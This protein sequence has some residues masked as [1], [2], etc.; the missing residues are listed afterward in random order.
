MND[1]LSNGNPPVLVE[2]PDEDQTGKTIK[3]AYEPVSG[4]IIIDT[5]F[6]ADED[7]YDDDGKLEFDGN[8]NPS[9]FTATIIVDAVTNVT[10]T[11]EV[12]YSNRAFTVV[13]IPESEV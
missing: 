8:A 7:G 2:L 13:N 12:S 3:W 1:A 10:L 4:D 9:E 6:T 5:S 11:F